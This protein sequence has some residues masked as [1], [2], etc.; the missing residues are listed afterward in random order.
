MAFLVTFHVFISTLSIQSLHLKSIFFYS[1]HLALV[2][3]EL[4]LLLFQLPGRTDNEIKN[5]WNT[6]S[7]RLERAGIPLYPDSVLSRVSN[8][9]INCHSP[10]EPHGKKCTNELSQDMNCHNLEFNDIVF[11]NLDYKKHSGKI[12]I[13]NFAIPNTLSVDA[14][15][16]LKGLASF[17]SIVSGYNGVLTCEQPPG[18]PEK[19]CYSTDFNSGITK[20]QS[21]PVG[22]AIASGHPILNGNFS[23]SG[24]IQR[25]M[26]MELP[27]LQYPNYDLSNNWLYNCPSGSPIEQVDT[28]TQSPVPVSLK[29]EYISSQNTGLLDALVHEGHGLGDPTISQGSFEVSFSPASY[30]QV[31]QSN[32]YPMSSS[33][34]ALGDSLFESSSLDEFQTSKSP[35]SKCARS[36]FNVVNVT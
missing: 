29:S 25:P 9:D 11:E 20:N 32:A 16:P 5:Y 10:D 31:L 8:Q 19:T 1:C 27:S 35:S 30:N 26:K 24:T 7:K 21:V 18:E 13:P 15:N 4:I 6:R 2:E 12:V 23:T 33:S 3:T 36:Y 28:F 17:D 34:S 22:S 14:M